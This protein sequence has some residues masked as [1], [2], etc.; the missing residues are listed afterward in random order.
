MDIWRLLIDAPGG[1]H[2]NMA[3]D[4]AM[5]IAHDSGVFI[6]PTLRLY[7]W[8]APSIS[9]GR[10]Q[11]AGTFAEKGLPIVRRATGGRAVLHDA[12]ITYSIVAGNHAPFFSKG[13][14]DT[15]F[16]ISTII[17]G[18][19]KEAGVP[20]E[21]SKVAAGAGD[22]EA[23]FSAHSRFEVIVN[24]KKL[25]GS[26][27][28]RIKDSFLQHGSIVLDIDPG[29]HDHVFGP[30]AKDAMTSLASLGVKDHKGF[31]EAIV[32]GL[33]KGLG[34]EFY[35]AGLSKEEELLKGR[36][37]C[38][39]YSTHEWNMGKDAVATHAAFSPL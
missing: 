15:Y 11:E 19:L 39:K 33:S 8:E 23:C 24:G 27:Q 29:L 38:S 7:S 32:K 36:L 20:A 37:L 9:I 12:E 26:A 21:V 6:A 10:M 4:E 17:A 2:E 3:K 34:I 35:P 1:A 13:I 16:I 5:L 14:R 25:V 31:L 18:A 30:R 28:R 22:K